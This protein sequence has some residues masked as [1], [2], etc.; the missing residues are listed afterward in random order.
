MNPSKT[1]SRMLLCIS[2]LSLSLVAPSHLQILTRSGEGLVEFTSTPST[3]VASN[4]ASGDL[5]QIGQPEQL[6]MNHHRA[7]I[8]SQDAMLWTS[9]ADWHITQARITDLNHDHIPEVT[10]L[11]WRPFKPWPIDAYLP[12]PGRIQGFHNQYNRSC[13]LILIGWHRGAYRELW[14][15]SALADP[16]LDF[17]AADLD[18]DGRQELVTLESQYDT[19]APVAHAIALWEWNG[20]GFSL[21]SRG[22][23]G[24]FHTIT[25]IK[26]FDGQ[27]LLLVQGNLRR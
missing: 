20:F 24:R 7:E 25:A 23:Q 19:L 15:G 6:R 26:T 22:P 4:P 2:I 10:L 11:I 9:P 12:H 13:H 1:Q 3:W 18:Q 8:W 5:D 21:R 17:T 14:A 27:E 16:I